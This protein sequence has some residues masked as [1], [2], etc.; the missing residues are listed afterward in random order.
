MN[1]KKHYGVHLI[2]DLHNCNSAMFNRKG[3]KRFMIGLCDAIG[4]ERAVLHFW[5]YKYFPLAKHRA[6]AHL[7]GTSAVQFITTSTITIHTLD[8]L[9]KVYLD[10]FSCRDFQEKAVVNYCRRWFSGTVAKS[11]FIERL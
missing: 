6:P 9:K 5:D 7:K 1:V 2:I 3:I 11:T 8:A 10:I 4:M